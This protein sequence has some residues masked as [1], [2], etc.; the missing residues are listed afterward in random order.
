MMAL[1]HFGAIP[2]FGGQFERGLE[3]VHEQSDAA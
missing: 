3:E 1:R 2:L